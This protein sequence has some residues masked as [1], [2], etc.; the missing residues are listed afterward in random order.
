VVIP[1]GVIE[2]APGVFGSMKEI[3]SVSIPDSVKRIGNTEKQFNI[4]G[5]SFHGCS[6]LKKVNIP[7]SVVYIMPHSFLTGKGLV[8][9]DI[10]TRKLLQLGSY[11][12]FYIFNGPVGKL[13]DK[14]LKEEGPRFKEECCEQGICWSCSAPLDTKSDRKCKICGVKLH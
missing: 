4:T 14:R 6:K 13:L 11:E 7:D 2:I 10:S 3:T 8:E 12:I 1:E 5:G 9:V